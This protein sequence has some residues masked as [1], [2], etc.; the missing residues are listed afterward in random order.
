MISVEKEWLTFFFLARVAC[1]SESIC[2]SMPFGDTYI[3]GVSV[4]LTSLS[5]TRLFQRSLLLMHCCECIRVTRA[6]TR[7]HVC[8]CCIKSAN[9]KTESRVVI[10]FLQTVAQVSLKE[11]EREAVLKRGKNNRSSHL[12]ACLCTLLC[13]IRPTSS[14]ISGDP[15]VDFPSSL[16]CCTCPLLSLDIDSRS[17]QKRTIQ[18]LQY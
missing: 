12:T 1:L 5:P 6:A 10:N 15:I 18:V 2:K 7:L 3:H 4:S 13:E 9:Q 14:V 17:I 11:K 8:C 16:S